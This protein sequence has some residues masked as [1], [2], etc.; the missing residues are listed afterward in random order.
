VADW[1]FDAEIFIRL[2]K[3]QY[4]AY[5]HRIADNRLEACRRIKAGTK[6]FSRHIQGIPATY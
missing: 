3:K 5:R 2:K 1:L 4:L 6:R